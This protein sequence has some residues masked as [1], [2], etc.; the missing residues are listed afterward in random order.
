MTTP[1]IMNTEKINP[2]A[3]KK[4]QKGIAAANL[5]RDR[6]YSVDEVLCGLWNKYGILGE[7]RQEVVKL[8]WAT[9]KKSKDG[10]WDSGPIVAVYEMTAW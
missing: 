3:M 4:I 2:L 5:W 8:S 7:S 6:G 1:T 10:G 9:C